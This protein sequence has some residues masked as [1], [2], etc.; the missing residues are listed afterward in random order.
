M[1]KH[2]ACDKQRGHDRLG[3][4]GKSHGH[5]ATCYTIMV[6]EL[7]VV[8]RC[9]NIWKFAKYKNSV[10]VWLNIVVH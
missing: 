5:M 2:T 10:L 3:W 6:Q 1:Y 7:I 9:E 8:Y 4:D